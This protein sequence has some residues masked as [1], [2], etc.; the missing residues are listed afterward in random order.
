MQVETKKPALMDAGDLL[1]TKMTTVEEKEIA[2]R[3][4]ITGK[5]MM[6]GKKAGKIKIGSIRKYKGDSLKPY[7]FEHNKTY[8]IPKWLADWLNGEGNEEMGTPGCHKLIHTD[9]NVDLN[10]MTLLQTPKKEFYFSFTP[11]AQW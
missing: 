4:M 10:N 11:V 9:Q 1:V 8:T 5:F 2:D 6:Q 3:K 7:I